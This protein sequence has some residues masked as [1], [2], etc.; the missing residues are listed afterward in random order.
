MENNNT[1]N[2]YTAYSPIAIRG[3]REGNPVLTIVGTVGNM[4]AGKTKNGED[5]V[6]LTLNGYMRDD[7]LVK[8][9][10]GVKPKA[11]HAIALRVTILRKGA[12]LL[13]AHPPKF[14]QKVLVEVQK[15]T[16]R[17]FKRKDGTEDFSLEG[18]TNGVSIFQDDN[19]Y[20]KRVANSNPPVYERVQR[21]PVTVYDFN[22]NQFAAA[23]AA[24]AAKPAAAPKP[25]PATAPGVTNYED[26]FGDMSDDD[27]P[28]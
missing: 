14:G 2:Q 24:G 23:P 20:Y 10:D 26:L 12:E 4:N 8:L 21:K 15:P 18:I 1:Q 28:F 9:F 17:T 7:T 13:I 16:V 27:L 5:M 22:G 19:A 6:A 3:I 25:A 11:D